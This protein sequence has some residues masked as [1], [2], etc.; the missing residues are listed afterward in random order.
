LK[1]DTW[2]VLMFKDSRTYEDE[3]WKNIGWFLVF[4]KAILE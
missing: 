2:K 1:S 4:I 3:T